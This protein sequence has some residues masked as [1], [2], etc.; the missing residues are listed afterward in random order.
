VVGVRHHHI[1]SKVLLPANIS[2][3]K[4]SLGIEPNS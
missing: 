1:C 3:N 2:Y 4:I